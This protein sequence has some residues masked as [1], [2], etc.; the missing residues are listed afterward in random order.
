MCTCGGAAD[1]PQFDRVVTGTA[2]ADNGL[3]ITADQQGIPSYYCGLV[4]WRCSRWPCAYVPHLDLLVMA[5]AHN[6]LAITAELNR[7]HRATVAL[8]RGGAA[9]A[10]LV[11]HLETVLS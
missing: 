6:C 10:G 11:P 9:A 3:A 4:A 8:Q 1:V 2:A 5:A 7:L